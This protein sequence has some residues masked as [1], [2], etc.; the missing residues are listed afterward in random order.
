MELCSMLRGQDGRGVQGSMD[1][2]VC[3]MA[4]SLRSATETITMLLTGYT[5]IKKKLKNTQNT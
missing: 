2:W 1:T 4:E 5:S 3:P